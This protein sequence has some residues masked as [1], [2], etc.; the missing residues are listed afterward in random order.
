MGSREQERGEDRDGLTIRAQRAHFTHT[1]SKPMEFALVAAERGKREREEKK[2]LISF[3]SLRLHLTP[4]IK[5]G[6]KHGA[7]TATKSIQTQ[8]A[9]RQR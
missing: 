1:S 4:S 3:G 5:K 9:R 2:T 8:R 6:E 7:C